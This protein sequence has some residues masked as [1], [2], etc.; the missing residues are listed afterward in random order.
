MIEESQETGRDNVGQIK[1]KMISI[2]E[3]KSFGLK[4]VNIR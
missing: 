4:I 1:S 2:N 3:Q